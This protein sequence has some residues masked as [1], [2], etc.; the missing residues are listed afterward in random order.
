MELPPWEQITRSDVEY[1]LSHKADQYHTHNGLESL[2][3]II[4][5]V[6]ELRQMQETN[7][8]ELT[9]LRVKLDELSRQQA[10]DSNYR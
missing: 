4:S 8:Q 7:R 2:L 6:R 1:M 5:I 9:Q 10:L 3:S